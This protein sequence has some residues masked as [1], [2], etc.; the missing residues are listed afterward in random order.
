VIKDFL[1][2]KGCVVNDPSGKYDFIIEIKAET[3]AGTSAGK[4]YQSLLNATIMAVDANTEDEVVSLLIQ[5]LKGAKYDFENAS[6]DAY[7]KARKRL[8]QE[9]LPQFIGKLYN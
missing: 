4:V 9:F 3:R 8:E 5:D 6:N 2:E 1:I 7:A